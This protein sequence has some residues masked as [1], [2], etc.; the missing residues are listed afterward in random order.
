MRPDP[1]G[2]YVTAHRSSIAAQ[3]QPAPSEGPASPA[4]LRR[5]LAILVG[6]IAVVGGQGMMASPLLPDIAMSFGVGPAAIG[7]AIGVYGL[8]TALS[9]LSAAKMLDTLPRRRALL[10]GFGLLA[11]GLTLSA[12][13]PALLVLAIAQGLCGL[14]AG[15]IIPTAYAYA[16]DVAPPERRARVVG[17]ALFGW[18]IAL[19]VAIPAGGFLG[20]LIG[21][22]GVF[23]IM[24]ALSL[25]C[26]VLMTRL[27]KVPR[28]PTPRPSYRATL[29]LPGARLGLITCL[30]NMAA[31]FGMYS[32]LGAAV[33]EGLATGSGAGNGAAALVVLC[34]G[35]GF[36]AGL[37]LGGMIDRMGPPRAMTLSMAALAL[38][39]VL[40]GYAANAPTGGV[41]QACAAITALGVAQHT[42]LNS[43][44]SV[45]GSL[46]TERRGSLMALNT[47][48][49]YAGVM[50]GSIGMGPVL[51]EYGFQT[52]TWFSSA[53]VLSGAVLSTMLWRKLN[54]GGN[55]PSLQ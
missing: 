6:A 11:A 39:F 47:A 45:L 22:R 36:T 53:V 38:L 14:A 40:L 27:P 34:Y 48:V 23:G 9:A 26:V 30:C 49:T 35:L 54:E 13:A 24:A 42:A 33:R 31:F 52:V 16:A 19:V 15:V 44:V 29:S 37:P 4:A 43:I 28:L 18:S 41:W 7:Q 10:G 21:W 25:A 46:S 55:A 8:A 32:Y 12:L 5:V 2:F 50:I 17:R 51:E 1:T 3:R 20:G